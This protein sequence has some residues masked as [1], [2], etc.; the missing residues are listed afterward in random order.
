V[1]GRG[2][3]LALGGAATG[4]TVAAVILTQFLTSPAV[5]TTGEAATPSVNATATGPSRPSRTAGNLL[6]SPEATSSVLASSSPAPLQVLGEIRATLRH[7]VAA[8]QIRQDVAVDITNLI[9]PVQEYLAAGATAQVRQ[10]VATLRT[11]LA[12]RLSEGAIS[13][14]AS[15]QL[16]GELTALLR[17]VSGTG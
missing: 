4:V 13:R 9:Q 3:I 1:R 17:S 16:G 2:G 15:Q 11:K 14:A 8:G 7:G 5:R 12:A 6:P 10:L